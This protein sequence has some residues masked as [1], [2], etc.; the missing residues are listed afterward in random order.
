MAQAEAFPSQTFSE[1]HGDEE[2]SLAR[3]KMKVAMEHDCYKGLRHHTG[4]IR[5]MIGAT[6]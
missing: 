1:N 6:P 4:L 5:A 3:E 2:S